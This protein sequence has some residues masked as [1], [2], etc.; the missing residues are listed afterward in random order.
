MYLLPLETTIGHINCSQAKIRHSEYNSEHSDSDR[1]TV[2]LQV[3]KYCD[4]KINVKRPLNFR[5]EQ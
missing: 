4:I 2:R 1:S 5:N 3:I